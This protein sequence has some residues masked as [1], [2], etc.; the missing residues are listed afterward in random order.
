MHPSLLRYHLRRCQTMNAK[1][2]TNNTT[3]RTVEIII[4]H[5]ADLTA[6]LSAFQKVCNLLSP[7][8]WNNGKPKSRRAL[9]NAAYHKVKGKLRSQMT[10]TAIR[11]FSVVFACSS[12]RS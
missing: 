4:E 12:R 10:Q 5:D 8:G 6:T 2:Q 7:I 9:H 11:F 3:K 1:M